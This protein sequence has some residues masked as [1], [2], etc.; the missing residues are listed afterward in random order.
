MAPLPTTAARRRRE[1]ALDAAPVGSGPSR[2]FVAPFVP[3][4]YDQTNVVRGALVDVDL[5]DARAERRAER[6]LVHLLASAGRGGD[7][8][9]PVPAKLIE[10][11]FRGLDWRA[12]EGAGIVGVAPYDRLGGRCR[13]F[14]V[15]EPVRSEFREAGPTAERVVRDGLYDLA[16]GRPT[17]RRVKSDRRTPS[18]NALPPLV[19]AAID[20]VG[21]VPVD[22]H[23]VERHLAALRARAAAAAP[24]PERVAAETRYA[25]D[26]RCYHAVLTQ[27]AR[28]LDPS[29]P[30]GLWVYRPAYRVQRFGRLS[31]KGGGL[32]SCSRAMKA[33]AY[34]GTYPL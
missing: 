6:F 19:R 31:Q 18:G 24:G 22:V 8:L 26:L 3:G 4:T 1:R 14:A 11:E 30:G 28:P 10:R 7:G 16:T 27:G 9:V 13:E 21:E 12:L 34:P 25:N 2:G 20:A 5:A 32:Q 17:R 15:L 33:V 23:A 29:R